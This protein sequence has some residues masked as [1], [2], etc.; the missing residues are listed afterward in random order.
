MA[1]T[2]QELTPDELLAIQDISEVANNKFLYKDASWNIVWVD[3]WGWGDMSKSVYDTNDDWIVNAAHKEL[4][5]FINK[6]GAT[7]TKWTIVYLK[8]TSSSWNF[9]E[10]L[11][12]NASTETTSSKTIGA[13]Y[14]DVDIDATGYIV[15]SGEVDNLNTSSYTVG[16]KLWLATTDWNVTTTPP[17]APNH[18]VFIGTVTRSQTTNG[19]ILYAIQNGYELEELHDVS[20]TA[21]T[22]IQDVDTILVKENATSLWKPS[23]WS[24]I[25]SVLKTYLDT[26]YNNADF[27]KYSIVTSVTS[28]NLTVAIKNYAGNDPTPTAPVKIQIG[29]T[30]RTLTGALSLTTSSWSNLHNAWST[31]LATQEVDYFVYLVRSTVSNSVI[32]AQS[33]IPY[34]RVQSDWNVVSIT[35]EK[36]FNRSSWANSTDQVEN[37]WRFNAIL[38]ATYQWSIPATS[39]IINRPIYETR[40]LSC[41]LSFVWS[42]WV[43]WAYWERNSKYKISWD[44]IKI[45]SNIRAD[46]NTLSWDVSQTL[47]FN[48]S[49]YNQTVYTTLANLNSTTKDYQWELTSWL[50][51]IQKA[52]SI[53]Y[54]QYSDMWSNFWIKWTFEYQIS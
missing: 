35:D 40:V 44:T 5:S 39:I 19:R 2:D 28:G 4:V 7:L 34:M 31:E 54:Y 18:T 48:N 12:A 36:F 8:T 53:N 25:K 43:A 32:I 26:L 50:L 46:K 11:K 52:L 23:T 17:S 41:L 49:F 1:R 51:K 15:T 38:S 22:N 47:P 29:N 45:L 6:T 21:Y 16:T 10:A 9:P 24:N 3:W 13:I 30:V 27:Y 37:I 42:S 33:R 20:S 14:E